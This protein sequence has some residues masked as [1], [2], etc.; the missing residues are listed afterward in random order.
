M[1]FQTPAQAKA[2]AE[3]A[4]LVREAKKA[5]E[6]ALAQSAKAA[7]AAQLPKSARMT[8]LR[9]RIRK[10]RDAMEAQEVPAE[11]VGR[12]LE[13]DFGEE[14]RELGMEDELAPP[15]QQQQQQQ[16]QQGV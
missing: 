3:A 15:E 1:Y 6:K 7:E 11:E 16:Q 14:A 9:T 12:S 10:V 4:K 5:A 8:I 2:K 13:D